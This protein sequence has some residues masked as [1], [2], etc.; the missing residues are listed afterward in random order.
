MHDNLLLATLLPVKHN[1]NGSQGH[2][3]LAPL[4]GA[5]EDI[6]SVSSTPFVPATTN[7]MLVASH[8]IRIFQVNDQC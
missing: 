6:N 7:C 3:C 8:M 1:S 2:G 4:V 5:I